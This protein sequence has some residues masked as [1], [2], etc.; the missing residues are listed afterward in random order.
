MLIL[1]VIKIIIATRNSDAID[2]NENYGKVTTIITVLTLVF[3]DNCVIWIMIKND[4]NNN[5]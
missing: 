3:N 1:T 4:K 5:W 2:N